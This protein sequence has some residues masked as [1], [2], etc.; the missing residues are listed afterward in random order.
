MYTDMVLGKDKII[1][2]IGC[3]KSYIAIQNYKLHASGITN[4]EKHAFRSNKDR[5]TS[6]KL[7]FFFD[8]PLVLRGIYMLSGGR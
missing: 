5:D 3:E 2:T 7:F 4:I 1:K 6:N 8:N